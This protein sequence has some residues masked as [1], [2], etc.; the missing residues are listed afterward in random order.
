MRLDWKQISEKKKHKTL[1]LDFRAGRKKG[2]QICEMV[3]AA[4][5]ELI[6][7]SDFLAEQFYKNHKIMP[8]HIVPNGTSKNLSLTE[9]VYKDI[10][11]SAA[12]SLIALKQYDIFISAIKKIRDVIPEANAVLCGKGPEEN[13]LKMLISELDLNKTISLTGELSHDNVLKI[14]ARSKIFLHPSNYEG[15]SSTCLEALSAGAYVISF[16]KPMNAAINHWHVVNSEKEMVEKTL[17]ILLSSETR[18][19]QVFPYLM[20]GSAK[21]IMALFR[22]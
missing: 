3:A 7:M 22:L 9:N 16:C 15:F 6:A 18:Y 12:G 2:K 21:E 10:S 13:K 4:P 11:I 5:D 14:M 20:E 1:L 19:S 17:E 8:K